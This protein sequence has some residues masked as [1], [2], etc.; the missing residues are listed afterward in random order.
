MVLVGSDVT[1]PLSPSQRAQVALQLAATHLQTLP[2]LSRSPAQ[3]ARLIFAAMA[4]SECTLPTS[5]M[6]EELGE[7]PRSVGRALPRKV[8]KALPDLARTLPDQGSAMEHHIQVA[9]QHTRRLALLISGHLQPALEN[10]LGA[11]P[12]SEAIAGSPQ[13]LDLIAT[14]TSSNMDALRNRLG[15]AR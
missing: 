8:K 11:L 4:A 5:I 6:K 13:A 10:V 7:L 1:T 12:S 15:F 9:L 14:W 2:L 3:A